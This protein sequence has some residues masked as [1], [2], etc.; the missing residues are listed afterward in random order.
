PAKQ[1]IADRSAGLSSQVRQAVRMMSGGIEP[2]GQAAKVKYEK[3]KAKVEAFLE[4]FNNFYQTDV[5]NFKKFVKESGFTLF[6]S[7]KPLKLEKK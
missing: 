1:G 3:V 4:K 5:E 2:I 7:F 6:I